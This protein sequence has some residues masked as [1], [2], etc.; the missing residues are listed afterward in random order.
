MAIAVSACSRHPEIQVKERKKRVVLELGFK[1]DQTLRPSKA[2]GEVFAEGPSRFY[3][4]VA[5]HVATRGRL[6]LVHEKIKGWDSTLS[7]FTQVLDVGRRFSSS[8]PSR[9][10][11]LGMRPL[12]PL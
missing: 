3:T 1:K 9:M 4:V 7:R 12:K 8:P 6:S 11:N 10:Q 2:P 5:E